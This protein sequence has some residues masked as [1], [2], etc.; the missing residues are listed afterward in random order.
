M[1]TALATV[2]NGIIK[3]H[4]KYLRIGEKDGENQLNKVEAAHNSTMV[5]VLNRLKQALAH[6][7]EETGV[8]DDELLASVIVDTHGEIVN[9]M[10]N[11]MEDKQLSS[12]GAALGSIK[13]DAKA[14]AARENG[15]RG[16]RPKKAG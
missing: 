5:R 3:E 1:N 11:W 2:A 9:E 14:A 8:V 13:S 12:G 4:D 7:V 6:H 15:K 10:L 16:G